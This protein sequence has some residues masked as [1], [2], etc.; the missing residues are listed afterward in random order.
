MRS[1][2]ASRAL[3]TGGAGFIGSSAARR[4]VSE[5]MDVVLYD[6]LSRR[7]AARTARA[8]CGDPKIS[9]VEGD[10]A[11][12]RGVEALFGAHGPFDLILHQAGQVAVTASLSDP[13]R[14]FEVNAA[15]TL[16]L[17]LA[18]RAQADATSV[19]PVFLYPSTN[20][21]YGTLEGV[22]VVEQD[23]RRAFANLPFGV[24]EEM[25]LV[26]DVPYAGS[27]GIAERYVEMFAKLYG[28]PAVVF[29]QS[30]IYGPGQYGAEEQGWV[31]WFAIAAALGRPVTLFGDG[32]QL[33]DVLSIDD[34]LDLYVLA[35]QRI[36]S[37]S[38]CVFNVGGGPRFTLS[39]NEL[40]TL[41]ASQGQ[42]LVVMH[43]APRAGDQAVYVSDVSRARRL[44]GWEPRIDPR[45]G[46]SLLLGWVSENAQNIREVLGGS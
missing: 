21:V 20:K 45:T 16:N 14:D 22:A 17:L 33:R 2:S 34:L 12:V 31:A 1:L 32:K 41:L 10:V 15:G 37:V 27:K 30:C 18:A 44:L 26:F 4:L 23:S 6:D 13:R 19:A 43:Q 24:P 39:L 36:E 46:V 42:P 11:D 3:V 28:L 5:G 35:Y 38:G 8:L 29:R 25:P 40:V 7:G 9:L